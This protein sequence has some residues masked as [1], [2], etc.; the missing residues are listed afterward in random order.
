MKIKRAF[1]ELSAEKIYKSMIQPVFTCCGTL[2]LYW[3]RSRKSRIKSIER[4]RDRSQKVMDSGES[5]KETVL[6]DCVKDN[7]CT[8]FKGY[9][10]KIELNINTRNNLV[11]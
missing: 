7:V 9:F 4:R 10:T 2:G 1:L 6:P 5:N 3:S 8:P 11:H